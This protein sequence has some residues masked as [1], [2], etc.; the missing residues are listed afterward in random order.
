MKR[1]FALLGLAFLAAC[2]SDEKSDPLATASGFCAEWAKRSCTER[3]V[4]RCGSGS[5]EECELAQTDACLKLVDADLYS[6]AGA[7]DCLK[8]VED[9]V[10][11]LELNAKERSL[12]LELGGDCAAVLSGDGEQGDKC[13]EPSDCDQEQGLT[14]VLRLGASAGTCEEPV[15]VSGGRSCEDPEEVC[16]ADFY[17]NE[18]RNC[19][20]KQSETETC[21][22]TVPCADGLNCLIVEDA[23]TSQCVAKLENGDEC[24]ADGDCE[25]GICRQGSSRKVCAA[26][27]LIDIADPICDDFN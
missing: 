5:A 19:I 21:S 25:S 12:F 10:K 20:E 18:D 24:E 6:K 26:T 7:R 27:V 17:C 15:E 1:W 11:D 9:A 23:G 22:V 14:C 3:V 13:T 2:G 8:A 16:E 4:S